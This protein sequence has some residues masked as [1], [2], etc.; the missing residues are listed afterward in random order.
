MTVNRPS[1]PQPPNRPNGGD[2]SSD[3]VKKPYEF[4]SFPSE[5]P[6]LQRP[7]GHHK[8]FSDRLHGTLYLTLKVQTPLHVSTGVVVMGSDIG[9]KIPLIK[10]MVQGVDQ[11]LSIQGSSLKGCIRSVYEAITNST[12]AVITNRYRDKIP[13]ERLPCR[14]K[15]QLCPASRVFGA[16][17]W[18]GL[19][20]FND[21]R[22]ENISFATGFMPS[23]YRPRPDE[24]GAYFIRSRVA[25]RKFYYHTIKAIDKGQNSGIP[26]QQAGREYI[27]TTQLHFKNLT[28][29]ELGTLL[30]VL[31]QDAKYPM[32]LKVGGGKPIGM[33]TMTVNIDKIHQPQNLKQRYSSYN[34]NQSD[35]LIGEK[36]QQFI[37][38]NIQAAHSHLIQKPQ[39][40][41]LAAILRYPTDREPPSGM[42]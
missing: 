21:A 36:L 1:R 31:G 5:R 32:A 9:Q 4:V 38:K 24:R 16:L 40:E 33:G 25:G 35:E 17:D 18:Q 15:E 6:N 11:K 14:Q 42:Y 13:P 3:F 12:L 10:T 34:L 27:F 19:L 22:C 23:L 8:Y 39:L 26:V 37:Q 29:E 30:I 41:E 20:D 28:V 7:A 2:S